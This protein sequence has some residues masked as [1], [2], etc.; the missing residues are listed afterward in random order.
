VLDKVSNVFGKDWKE[1]LDSIHDRL[2]K[3]KNIED[4]NFGYNKT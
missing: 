3:L 1:T 4:D 2:A